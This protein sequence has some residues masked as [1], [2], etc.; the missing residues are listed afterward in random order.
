MCLKSENLESSL[1]TEEEEE[2]EEQQR[3][4]CAVP[5]VYSTTVHLESIDMHIDETLNVPRE[6]TSIGC[7]YLMVSDDMSGECHDTCMQVPL[8][9]GR[10][11]PPPHLLDQASEDPKSA[12][13]R[14][15]D[16]TWSVVSFVFGSSS[17]ANPSQ[18][19]QSAA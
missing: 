18:S 9:L 2:E 19:H 10:Q 8:P 3:I 12:R 17:F 16:A 15:K 13:P 14:A 4:L 1:P 6:P 11:I 5:F 7:R